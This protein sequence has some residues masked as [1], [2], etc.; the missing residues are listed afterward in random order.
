M[1]LIGLVGGNAARR[2]EVA[3]VLESEGRQGLVVWEINGYR[4]GDGRATALRRALQ[5]SR[6]SHQPVR[7]IVFPHVL[8]VTEVDV[9]RAAGGFIWHLGAPL[10][11]LIPIQSGDLLV[12]PEADGVRQ[13]RG[14]LDA[15]SE[16]LLR[17]ESLRRPR[18][19]RRA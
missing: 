1:L 11:D 6:A 19:L 17:C 10:S 14:P 8:T 5:D 2:L 3:R 12:T 9:L 4:L 13:W 7:G 15:L 16:A 18:A